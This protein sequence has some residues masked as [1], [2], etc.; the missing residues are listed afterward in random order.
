MKQ[1]YPTNP[2]SL[3]RAC[4]LVLC[5]FVVQS[6]AAEGNSAAGVPVAG[7][8][9]AGDP[10]AGKALFKQ[11]CQSCHGENGDGQGE[12]VADTLPEPRDFTRAEF[13]FD[14]DADWQRGTS[15]DL[16]NVITN[17]AAVY[18]GSALMIPWSMLSEGD[19]ENLVAYIHSLRQ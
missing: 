10:V 5:T 13:K 9:A 7:I 6:H 14:T 17:G 4:V 1:I 19:V 18:G 16:A 11:N 2:L 12:A 8:P 3:A 15:K